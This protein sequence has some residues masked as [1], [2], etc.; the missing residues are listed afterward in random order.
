MVHRDAAGTEREARSLLADSEA[1]IAIVTGTAPKVLVD[2]TVLFVAQ[3]ALRRG[4]SFPAGAEA[5]I[6]FN[7]ELS[8]AGTVSDT[9]HQGLPDRSWRRG[10]RWRAW[11]PDGTPTDDEVV[12]LEDAAIVAE[13]IAT[14]QAGS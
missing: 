7:P 3:S 12:G 6:L 4:G 11:D 13:I 9:N 1:N 5:E 14:E 10:R 2:G 8:T